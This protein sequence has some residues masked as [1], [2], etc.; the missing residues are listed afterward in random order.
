MNDN[1]FYTFYSSENE[2]CIGDFLKMY[3]GKANKMR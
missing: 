3:G 1:V 2:Y